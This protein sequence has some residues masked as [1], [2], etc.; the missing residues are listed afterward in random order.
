MQK[1]SIYFVMVL[2]ITGN[3]SHSQ[4]CQLL[5]QQET[6]KNEA[7]QHL[8]TSRISRITF[9]FCKCKSI[10]K[11]SL[12]LFAA[13]QKSS[14]VS[15]QTTCSLTKTLF[16]YLDF[17]SPI[18]YFV[19]PVVS[20]E[21]FQCSSFDRIEY[22]R[23]LFGLISTSAFVTYRIVLKCATSRITIRTFQKWHY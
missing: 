7:Y 6:Q 15:Y 3:C 22:L 19:K 9:F 10:I 14:V 5:Y 11:T 17:F 8:I 21:I 2:K 4:M 16:F 13:V 23:F 20:H 12:H 18:F 1:F